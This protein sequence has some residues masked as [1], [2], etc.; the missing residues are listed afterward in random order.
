MSVFTDRPLGAGV[1]RK[2]QVEIMVN[3]R[4]VRDDARGVGEALNETDSVS[5][6]LIIVKSTTGSEESVI[7]RMLDRYTMFPLQTFSISNS[8]DVDGIQ[9]IRKLG[10]ISPSVAV[11][12][13]RQQN[14]GSV[15]LCLYH[16]ISEPSKNT[17]IQSVD[18]AA[19]LSMPDAHCEEMAINGVKKLS[20]LEDITIQ[21]P[22]LVKP[23]SLSLAAGEIRTVVCQP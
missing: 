13:A 19:L 14:D 8:S 5:G 1:L 12:T 23:A 15:L 18:L 10:E 11:L 21:K 9:P 22:G 16:K 4:T 3:R 6:R 7:A 17:T 2:G 20:D